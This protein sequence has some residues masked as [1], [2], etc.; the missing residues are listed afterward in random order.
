MKKQT[1]NRRPVACNG[2]A[3]RVSPPPCVSMK[4]LFEPAAVAP[5]PAP[6]GVPSFFSQPFVR[7]PRPPPR[8]KPSDSGS[9]FRAL[10]AVAR[11]QEEKKLEAVEA[12]AK[13][14]ARCYDL[15]HEERNRA[16]AKSPAE[17]AEPTM[18]AIVLASERPVR[19]ARAAPAKRKPAAGRGRG[20]PVYD[21]AGVSALVDQIQRESQEQ[22]D[23][24][25]TF[26]ALA[27]AFLSDNPDDDGSWSG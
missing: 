26:G 16:Q 23:R 25:A 6:T 24:Q 12:L 20:E 10:G 19:R 17:Q 18:P 22:L 4:S 13:L 11:T 9:L 8:E 14:K 2:L 21:Q 27:D 1:R 7:P 5:A 3:E 15:I